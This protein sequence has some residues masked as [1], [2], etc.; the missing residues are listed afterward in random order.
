MRGFQSEW[1]QPHSERADRY[2][3]M[4]SL[5]VDR[6]DDG[7]A[8]RAHKE[9]DNVLDLAAKAGSLDFLKVRMR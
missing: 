1:L 4:G 3:S 9:T 6:A 8:G 5:L 7:M 2:H